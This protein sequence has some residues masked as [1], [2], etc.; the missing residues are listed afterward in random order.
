MNIL[1]LLNR[2]GASQ[3]LRLAVQYR[4]DKIVARAGQMAIRL[5]SML[6]QLAI[7]K[8]KIVTLRAERDELQRTVT[9][10]MD[11]GFQFD[12]RGA[13]YPDMTRDIL[14]EYSLGRAA[15]QLT[16][17]VKERRRGSV[18]TRYTD[19]WN[20]RMQ[21]PEPR[22]VRNVLIRHLSESVA[23]HIARVLFEFDGDIAA[24]AAASK[25]IQQRRQR[26]HL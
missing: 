21:Y 12:S 9:W 3:R 1:T 22:D 19:E 8:A 18:G 14:T 4:L 26:T 13:R 23:V 17:G 16:M 10:L 11:N 15:D 2:A 25:E 6:D 5:R 24:E 20:R 7:A